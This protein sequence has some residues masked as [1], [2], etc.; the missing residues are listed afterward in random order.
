MHKSESV[1]E[2]EICKI[3]WDF[4]IQ[5][6]HLIPA[7]KLDIV[8]TNKKEILLSGRFFR[9]SGPKVRRIGNELRPP[10]LQD[11]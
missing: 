3:I 5:T 11:C 10:K 6:D 1:L 4:E 7:R 2:N 8:L 9:F